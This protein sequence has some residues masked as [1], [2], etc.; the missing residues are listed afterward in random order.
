MVESEELKSINSFNG[1]LVLR[2][3]QSLA[4]NRRWQVGVSTVAALHAGN[5]QSCL[6]SVANDR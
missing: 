1:V 3:C 6:A 2:S 4:N 5:A